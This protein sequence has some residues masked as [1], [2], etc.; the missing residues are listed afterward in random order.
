MNIKPHIFKNN[1]VIGAIVRHTDCRI[2]EYIKSKKFIN[3]NNRNIFKINL[4]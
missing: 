2:I 1:S 4:N 3:E